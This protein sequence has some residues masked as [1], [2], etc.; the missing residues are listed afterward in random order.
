MAIYYKSLQDPIKDKLSRED[1]LKDIKEIVKKAIKIDEYLEKRRIEKKN[2]NFTWV[3]SHKT[4]RQ[5]MPYP[6]NYYR[7]RPMEV[8]VVQKQK[9]K[10][11]KRAL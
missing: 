8:N 9:G 1:A 10:T 2:W 7:L 6:N 3:P 11:K 4:Q 5:R